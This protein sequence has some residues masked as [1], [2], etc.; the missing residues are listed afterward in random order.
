MDP[1]TAFSLACNVI[2]VVDFST[3]IVVTCR[4][5][6]KDGASS[7]NQEIESMTKHLTD[8]FTGL[9]FTNTVTSPGAASHLY[10]DDQDLLK[11]AQQCSGTAIELIGE[12]EKL[13]T[14]SQQKKRDALRKAIKVLR[15]GGAI[16][17]IQKRLEQHRRAL[18]TRILINLRFVSF[19]VAGRPTQLI[20]NEQS[21]TACAFGFQ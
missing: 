15:K 19:Q 12:L 11:L 9:D 18:D 10:H 8:L 13:R 2:Q 4:E 20:C 21:Q 3:K 6:Y 17:D 5:L 7:K 16:K 1:L 14:Q